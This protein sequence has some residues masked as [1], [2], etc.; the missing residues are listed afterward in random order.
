MRSHS[1]QQLEAIKSL[2]RKDVVRVYVAGNDWTTLNGRNFLLSAVVKADEESPA[3]TA[4]VTFVRESDGVTLSPISGAQVLAKPGDSIKITVQVSKQGGPSTSE[5]EIFSGNI[6]DVS[7]G[8]DESVVTL[9]ARDGMARVIESFIEEPSVYSGSARRIIEQIASEWGRGAGIFTS[10]P[11]SEFLEKVPFRPQSVYSAIMSLADT[12]GADMRMRYEGPQAVVFVPPSGDGPEAD[13]FTFDDYYEVADYSLSSLGVRDRVIVSFLEEGEEYTL[14]RS[15]NTPVMGTYFRPVYIDERSNPAVTNGFAAQAVADSLLRA[16]ARAPLVQTVVGPLDWRIELGDIL[17]YEPNGV[18]TQ[19]RFT[20]AVTGFTHNISATENTTTVRVR[21]SYGGGTGR[22]FTRIRRSQDSDRTIDS[23]DGD[24]FY[25]SKTLNT[26]RSGPATQ[27]DSLGRWLS[28]TAVA[29]G[30]NNLF[31]PFTST[32][33]EAGVTEYRSIALV[34][35]RGVRWGPLKIWAEAANP[36]PLTKRP[37][38]LGYDFQF[39]IDQRGARN[40]DD[41]PIGSFSANKTSPAYIRDSVNS[42]IVTY[43]S[44]WG[45][46]NALTMGSLEPNNA[47]V[48]HVKFTAAPGAFEVIEDRLIAQDC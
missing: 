4:T 25:T 33:I 16:L 8:G 37:T 14:V 32:Q 48:I 17:G 21:G 15:S 10:L 46:E 41:D 40:I 35:R 7:F 26:N 24:W 34:N 11:D 13:T 19:S 47:V 38:T 36:D 28:T 20:G 45:K 3:A 2:H 5:V 39:A 22:W 43:Q 23:R 29:S 9:Q 44:A 42:G 18:H 12:L 27:E 31:G 6:D 1:T 30:M